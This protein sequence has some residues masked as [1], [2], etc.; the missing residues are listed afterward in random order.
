MCNDCISNYIP[1]PLLQVSA[2]KKTPAGGEGLAAWLTLLQARSVV[3]DAL[4]SS[5]EMP[6]GWF[7]VLIQLT[8][9]SEGR[10]KMQELAHSVLLSK[11]G[12][13]RLVDRMAEAGLVIRGPCETDRRVVYATVTPKGRAALRKALPA[14]NEGLEQHFSSVLTPPELGMLRSTLGKILDAAGFVPAPCPTNLP[15]VSGADRAKARTR[16]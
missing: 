9:S 14:H 6:L 15:V 5:V 13:T 11:S 4:E 10:L 7:E 3:V 8:S 16:A 12:L 2:T 1:V